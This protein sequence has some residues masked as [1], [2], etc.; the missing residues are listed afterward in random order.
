M[1][2]FTFTYKDYDAQEAVVGQHHQVGWSEY[3]EMR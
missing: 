3:M 2:D 1:V